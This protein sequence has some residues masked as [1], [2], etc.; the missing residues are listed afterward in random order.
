MFEVDKSAFGT[1]RLAYTALQH[2]FLPSNKV[3]AHPLI[4]RLLMGFAQS[5]PP[6]PA[7]KLFISDLNTALN[8][9]NV[10]NATLNLVDLSRKA[11]MLLLLQTMI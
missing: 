3:M 5:R 10:S 8:F 4:K 11:L 9:C 2:L 7:L 1:I 6:Q